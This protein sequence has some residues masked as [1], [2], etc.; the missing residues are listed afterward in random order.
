VSGQIVC[1]DTETTGTDPERHEVWE[2]GAVVR[3]SVDYAG[4]W[5]W[6]VKP[7]LAAAD[8]SA[9]RVNRYYQ[10]HAFHGLMYDATSVC[11]TSPWWTEEE[12]Q[13]S[14]ARRESRQDIAETL[15]HILAGGVV[16]AANPAF[17]L[18][19]LGKFLRRHGQC[20]VWDYHVGDI[21]S[22]AHGYLHGRGG[23]EPAALS[24]PWKSDR[25]AAAC[26]V[27]PA[28]DEDRH[29]ALGDARWVARWYDTITGPSTSP[30]STA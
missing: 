27:E 23:G 4:E 2:I 6:Q 13:K 28:A 25:L 24:L 10:R 26:G 19:F 8:P 12:R 18:T 15:A 7:D 5:L 16:F 14:R 3:D 9:L 21:G 20:G 22:I 17:D 11:L 29:T 1:L 30:A